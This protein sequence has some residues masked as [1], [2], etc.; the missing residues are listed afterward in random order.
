MNEE[1][2][3]QNI[4]PI[5]PIKPKTPLKIN[6]GLII[7]IGAAIIIS[8]FILVGIALAARIWDPLWNPFR[9]EPEEII[10]QMINNMKKIEQI[11]SKARIE[12][13]NLNQEKE[14]GLL[15]EVNNNSDTSNKDNMKLEGNF[16]LIFSSEG[17]Q[18]LVAGDYKKADKKAFLKLTTVPVLPTISTFIDLSILKDQWIES[19]E[20]QQES[21]EST[22]DKILNFLGENKIYSIKK[23]LSDEEIDNK[24]AYHFLLGLN[25][26]S[27]ENL[28]ELIKSISI[29]DD[30]YL[31][32]LGDP[33]DITDNLLKNID[34]LEVEVWIGK[35]D[36]LIYKIGLY[37][38]IE[39][40]LKDQSEVKLSISLEI[41]FSNF[42]EPLNIKAPEN[43]KTMEEILS[44][45]INV[46]PADEINIEI[47][48]SMLDF[49]KYN[50]IR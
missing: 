16:S 41:N 19:P 3:T 26:L 11:N 25:R 18:I 31:N 4:G 43:T 45:F 37:K 42:N 40:Q 9:P 2:I 12:V 15:I 50:I 10:E 47:R 39:S 20:N 33:G 6:K 7:K 38:E 36:K 29:P 17:S 44:P 49:D 8:A 14:Q 35:K 22:K 24:E 1:N 13:K 28:E 5:E 21:K 30:P 48:R 32:S 27:R 46:S 23:E 34:D